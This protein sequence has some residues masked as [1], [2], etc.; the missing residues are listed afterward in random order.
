MEIYRCVV[1]DGERMFAYDVS[2]AGKTSRGPLGLGMNLREIT[3]KSQARRM[4]NVT[5]D[6]STR[7]Q[8]VGTLPD[9]KTTSQGF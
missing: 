5:P 4:A 3:T 2:S 1:E 6:Y 8:D 7:I 9:T